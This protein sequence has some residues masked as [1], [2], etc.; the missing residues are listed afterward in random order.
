[1]Y[2]RSVKKRI[3]DIARAEQTMKSNQQA[4]LDIIFRHCVFTS[5]Y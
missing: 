5:L 4:Q 2:K 1:M 3:S